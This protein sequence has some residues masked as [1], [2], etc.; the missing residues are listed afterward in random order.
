[1]PIVRTTLEPW[2]DILVSDTEY[3]ALLR[4]G[5]IYDGEPINPPPAFTDA[6]YAELANPTGE[7]AQRVLAAALELVNESEVTSSVVSAALALIDTDLDAKVAAINT[8]LDG[9]VAV[10]G[11]S[12]D[13]ALAAR[14]EAETFAAGT[15]ALQDAAVT[16]LLETPESGSA[17]Q[18]NALIDVRAVGKG[19]LVINAKDFGATGDGSTDDGPAI[20]SALNAAGALVGL[21]LGGNLGP[22]RGA[23]V[24]IPDGDYQS[25]AP[26][27]IPKYVTVRGS[28][29]RSTRLFNNV[30]DLFAWG[31]DH[32]LC[33]YGAME[34]IWL[35]T[36]NSGG[37]LFNLDGGTGATFSGIANFAFTDVQMTTRNPVSSIWK[38]RQRAQ[39]IDITFD[40]VKM[41]TTSIRTVPAFDVSVGGNDAN[42]VRILN[43]WA[44]GHGTTAAPFFRIESGNAWNYSWTFS[45]VVGE[46][47]GGGFIHAYA[48]DGLVIENCP[49]WDMIGAYADD[50]FK[51]VGVSTRQPKNVRIEN[52]YRVANPGGLASGKFDV[53]APS[54]ANLNVRI[55]G[56]TPPGLSL[57]AQLAGEASI[58]GRSAGFRVLT[59]STALTSADPEE[60]VCNSATAIDVTLPAPIGLVFGRQFRIKNVGAGVVTLI[61]SIDGS[62]GHTLA[63]WESI[64]VRTDG[65]NAHFG[66]IWFTV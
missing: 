58:S 28:G 7:A 19:E 11:A 15:V 29:S 52:S 12:K 1:M 63:Q 31:D 56:C 34:H 55:V 30:G 21:D 8:D 24:L 43:S 5:L 22:R 54:A 36:G 57:L 26:Y 3:L 65:A 23:T 60:L 46:Q 38:Q 20:Q 41:D 61:G 64:T 42:S 32:G 33:N 13:A 53:N 2:R 59:A 27:K 16:V 4:V 37:H 47:N 40:R 50:V 6:Q 44:H 17:A 14:N 39:L 45:N 9:K 62:A 35:S 25:T 18:V 10:A 49:D 51:V 48:I 66:R